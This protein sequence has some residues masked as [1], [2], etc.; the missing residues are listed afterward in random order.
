M[1]EMVDLFSVSGD[2]AGTA[3]LTVKAPGQITLTVYDPDGYAAIML[4]GDLSAATA[5]KLARAVWQHNAQLEVAL[6]GCE[7]VADHALQ[8]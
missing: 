1:I 8:E 2:L 7:A 5:R 6:I 3:D 4:E